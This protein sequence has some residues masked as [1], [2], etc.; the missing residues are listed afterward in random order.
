MSDDD[1]FAERKAEAEAQ[2]EYKVKGKTAIITINR[3]KQYNAMN[4]FHYWA[5]DEAVQRAAREPPPP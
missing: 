1:G 4:V 5:L 3:P 2:I